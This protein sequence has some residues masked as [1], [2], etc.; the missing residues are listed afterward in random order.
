[1]GPLYRSV[2]GC[3]TAVLGVACLNSEAPI[4][5]N[6]GL[7]TAALSICNE[8]VPANRN[9]DGIPSY[10]QCADSNSASI[11]SNNGVDT[12]T[13]QMGPDWVK[14][15]WSG[16]YQCTELAHRYL[17]FKWGVKWIPNGNAG[18]WCDSQ[19]PA[20]SGVVQTMTPMHGDIMV[21]APGSC[22]ADGTTGHVTVVDVV[23]DPKL[24]VVEQNGARR[25]SYMASCAKCFL[26][27]MKNDGTPSPATGIPPV[28]A[29]AGAAAP[30]TPAT[31][32][33]GAAGGA[34]SP[35]MGPG[36][37]RPSM[38]TPAAPGAAGAAAPTTRPATPPASTAP[39]V[40]P[41][42]APTAPTNSPAPGTA[43]SMNSLAAGSGAAPLAGAVTTPTTRAAPPAA[44]GC[45]IAAPG[46]ERSH[47]L[48][49]A[50]GLSLVAGLALRRRQRRS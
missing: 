15:Q 47:G 14:T 17:Y 41:T 19:P 32:T 21:L 18:M 6:V 5:D 12:S 27:V 4:E 30:A 29:A 25:G 23:A 10:A 45:A 36:R 13:T 43:S 2:F 35:G 8:T 7:T 26:H 11:F 39:V 34:A 28:T 48:P 20:N 1:M 33:T 24:T 40:P 9:V 44:G 31:P 50:F 42:A 38:G 22:G 3:L 16:G 46:G 37:G 49:L